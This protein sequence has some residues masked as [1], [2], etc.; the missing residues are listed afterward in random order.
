MAIKIDFSS[1]VAR[2]VEHM[3]EK[4]Q[5]EINACLETIAFQHTVR[6]R[7]M[8][9]G[10]KVKTAIWRCRVGKYLFMCRVYEMRILI[11]AVRTNEN[12]A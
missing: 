7:S 12:S 3:D 11:T 8:K 4:I 2:E 5:K 9:P 6:M 10:E 1:E